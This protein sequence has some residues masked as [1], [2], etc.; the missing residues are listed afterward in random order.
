M[1]TAKNDI[2]GDKLASKKTNTNFRDNYD[3]IKWNSEKD[4]KREPKN[5]THIRKRSVQTID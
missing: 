2:T 5:S 1:K 3:L 4:E